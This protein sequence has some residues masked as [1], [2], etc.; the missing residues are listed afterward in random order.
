[1]TYGPSRLRGISAYRE[2]EREFSVGDRIQFTAPNR[3][4]H[5]ANRDLGTIEHIGQDG[6]LSVRMDNGKAVSFDANEMRHFD[7]GYAVTSHSSQG[8]TSER[9]LV[10]MDTEVHPDLINSRFAYVSISRASHEA[11]IYTNHAASLA[12][13]LSHDTTKTSAVT[14]SKE[15][16][17]IVQQGME[18]S[19]GQAK[20]Q[21]TGLGLAL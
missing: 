14:F 16:G 4:L 1:V 12:E 18:Q 9:V 21:D 2:I 20:V 5:V 11:H 8:L 17:I 10:N 19:V 15:H 13:S 7:H 3:T 6:Q